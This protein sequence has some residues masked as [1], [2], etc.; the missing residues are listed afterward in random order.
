M[1]GYYQ[2]FSILVS[3]S[4]TQTSVVLP[5]L[6]SLYISPRVFNHKLTVGFSVRPHI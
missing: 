2:L 5:L 1:A 4:T 6:P 3:G